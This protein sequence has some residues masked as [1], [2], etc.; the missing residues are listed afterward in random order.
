MA[1]YIGNKKIADMSGIPPGNYKTYD[2]TVHSLSADGYVISS[3]SYIS[4]SQLASA[5]LSVGKVPS[6]DGSN[7]QNAIS[8]LNALIDALSALTT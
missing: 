4:Q 7:L 6:G 1:L 2:D 5:I 8:V 3:D